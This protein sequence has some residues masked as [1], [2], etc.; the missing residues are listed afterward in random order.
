MFFLSGLTCDESNFSTKAGPLA[1]ATAEEENIAICLPDTS[2]RGEN[3]P[4]DENYDLGQGAG[5]YIDA[6]R[7]PW[8]TH[9]HMRSYVSRELPEFLKEEFGLDVKSVCGHSMGGFGALSL[10]FEN[11][12]EWTAVSA[13]APIANPTNCPW[14]EKAF[15]NYL[16][17][18]EN[19]KKYDPTSMLQAR[20]TGFEKFDDILI[21][22]G[23]DDNFLEEQLKPHLLKD[24]ADSCGQRITLNMRE[25]YDHSYF[26]IAAFIEDHVRFHAKRLQEKMSKM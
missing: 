8:K 15:T 2:P 11:P 13:F 9:F 5:F 14:G 1:F 7:D 20:E 25:G 23:S 6:M 26:F 21:D 24:A 22:Q 16:G 10:A 12:E 4:N 3:V 18:V 19:G 17:S